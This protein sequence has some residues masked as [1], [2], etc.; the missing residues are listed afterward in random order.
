MQVKQKKFIMVPLVK[1]SFMG[2]DISLP[3]DLYVAPLTT[4]YYSYFNNKKN[5]NT[6]IILFPK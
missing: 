6:F 3:Y 4:P 5:N 2:R 1:I